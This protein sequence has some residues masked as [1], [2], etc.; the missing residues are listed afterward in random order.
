M[1][2]NFS[3]ILILLTVLLS[4]FIISL[5]FIPAIKYSDGSKIIRF[6]A[7]DLAFGDTEAIRDIVVAS[8]NIKILNSPLVLL[9]FILPLIVSMITIFVHVISLKK[10]VI[11]P[12]ILILTLLYSTVVFIII[13]N[14]TFYTVDGVKH[15]FSNFRF[16]YTYYI[17]IAVGIFTLF[18]SIIY[19]ILRNK[20]NTNKK[21]F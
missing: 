2:K 15:G 18:T 3:F 7:A 10:A 11:M 14:I 20:F 4:T 9:A 1:K 13:R 8:G 6:S 17:V 16:S 12:A 21:F 19:A 5:M